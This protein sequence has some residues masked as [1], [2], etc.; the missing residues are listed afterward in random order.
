M[1]NATTAAQQH[2]LCFYFDLHLVI[3][4]FQTWLPFAVAVDLYRDEQSPNLPR[5]ATSLAQWAPDHRSEASLLTSSKADDPRAA[6]TSISRQE[7]TLAGAMLTIKLASYQHLG[8]AKG[9]DLS[10]DSLAS[11]P[12]RSSSR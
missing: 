11:R 10:S 5:D 3:D 8:S 4:I 12:R 9:M 6:S 7:T 2:Q 1:V